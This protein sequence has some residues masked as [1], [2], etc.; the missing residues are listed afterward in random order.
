MLTMPAAGALN[1][2]NTVLGSVCFRHLSSLSVIGFPFFDG[3]G[4]QRFMMLPL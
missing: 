3:K 2:D 1:G 4:Q